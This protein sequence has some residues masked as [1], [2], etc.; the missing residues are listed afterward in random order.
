MNEALI[1]HTY[2]CAPAPTVVGQ[3]T[4]EGGLRVVVSPLRPWPR[5]A[6]LLGGGRIGEGEATSAR[7][8]R[9]RE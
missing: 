7:E 4:D 6:H 3:T 9:K 5:L 8:N 1:V 2:S